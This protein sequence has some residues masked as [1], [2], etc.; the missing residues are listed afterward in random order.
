MYSNISEIYALNPIYNLGQEIC[1]VPAWG[2]SMNTSMAF[3]LELAR[4]KAQYN[5]HAKRL[6]GNVT[7]LAWILKTST[8]EFADIV[9]DE[10]RYS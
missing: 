1:E 9:P 3:G 6:L 4:D 8:P 7:V 10:G 2:G 5:E